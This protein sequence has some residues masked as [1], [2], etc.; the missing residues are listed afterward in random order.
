M[1]RL[2]AGNLRTWRHWD[3]QLPNNPFVPRELEAAESGKYETSQRQ[4]NKLDRWSRQFDL[5]VIAMLAGVPT[6]HQSYGAV[7]Y[8][9]KIMSFALAGTLP[10]V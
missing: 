6:L 10:E 1:L 8:T 9:F 4:R 7:T 2:E 5:R 3:G